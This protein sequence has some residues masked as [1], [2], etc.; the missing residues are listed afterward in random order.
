[1]RLLLLMCLLLPIPVYSN[2][3]NYTKDFVCYVKSEFYLPSNGKLKNTGDLPD[4]PEF[5]VNRSTGV[6]KGTLS[7]SSPS[8][9]AM[10][11][12]TKHGG[13]SSYYIALT[14][15]PNGDII[16]IRI[17]DWHNDRM[18]PFIYYNS[19]I[20]ISGLCTHK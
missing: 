14:K 11:A 17:E 19:N 3:S 4:N 7:N 2:N 18:K 6:I 9:N 20:V 10:P 13:D 8:K 5:V 16:I 1:M 15:Y 12:I